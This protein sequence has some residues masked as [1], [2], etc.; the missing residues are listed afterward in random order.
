M[1]EN[2]ILHPLAS[3]KDRQNRSISRLLNPKK[4]ER[5]KTTC[6]QSIGHI[7]GNDL[8]SQ[9]KWWRHQHVKYDTGTPAVNIV[10]QASLV[11]GVNFVQS[12]PNLCAK[13]MHYFRSLCLKSNIV[14]EKDAILIEKFFP[15]YHCSASLGLWCKL[16]AIY[17]FFLNQN[18]V[19]THFFDYFWFCSLY[20]FS[21]L[22]M[23]S[24][25]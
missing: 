3:P 5:K 24:L 20:L 16:M 6:S 11:Y 12:D 9:Y 19:T 7:G 14:S 4:K 13:T 10:N 25:H 15:R 22:I 1:Q 21:N 8:S 17:S 2:L 18:N 23:P